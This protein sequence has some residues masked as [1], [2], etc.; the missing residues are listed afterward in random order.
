MIKQKEELSYVKGQSISLKVFNLAQVNEVSEN[1]SYI[2]C[3][4]LLET[5]QLFQVNKIWGDELVLKS[6]TNNLL[7]E[8]V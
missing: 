4:S 8:F 7:Y 3:K 1:D 6:F 2:S 5:T